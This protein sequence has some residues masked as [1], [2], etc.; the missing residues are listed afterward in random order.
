MG[1]CVERVCVERVIVIVEIVIVIV[2]RVCG[3]E[4]LRHFSIFTAVNVERKVLIEMES[5]ER[6][7][8]KMRERWG[9]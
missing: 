7:Y 2:E 3:V 6:N 4:S 8:L 9:R 5:V 1:S